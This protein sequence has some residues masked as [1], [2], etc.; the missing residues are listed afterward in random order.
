MRGF[1]L[2]LQSLSKEDPEIIIR[3]TKMKYIAS[4]LL[5]TLFIQASYAQVTTNPLCFDDEEPVTIIYDATQGTTGLVG[6]AKVYMHA[7]VITD[8][9]TGTGWQYVIGNWGTDDGIGEMTK[10]AGEAN[11][12]E[13]TITPR[14]Y[15]NVPAS[16]VIYR[17]GM[18]FRNADGSK[19]GKNDSNGDIFINL[20]TDPVNLQI[21]STNPLLVDNGDM[22]SISA[23]TCSNATFNLYIN[24][25]LETTQSATNQFSYAYQVVQ[26]A[27]DLVE[28]RLTAEVGAD[29]NEKEFSFSVRTA[30]VSAP[31]PAG[32]IDGINYG[33]DPTKVTLSLLAPFK[34][35]VYVVGDFN[36]WS[37]DPA[38]QMKQDGERFW[39]EIT[40][41]ISGQE[42]GYQ[43]LV[44]ETIWIAD[45]YADKILDPDDKWIPDTTYPSLMVY[46]E[47][48][49]HS[50]WYHNRV[51]VIQTNQQAYNWQN[52]SFQKPAK[53][54]LVIYQVLVRDFLG[55]DNMNYQSLIDTLGYFE[56][57]GVNAI[58]LLPIMEFGGN[59]SW[60]Y[61]PT[62]MFA[63][64]KAYGTKNDLKAFID[65]AHGRGM[66]VI[67]DMVM[68][69]ND[70]PSPYAQMYF[71]FNTFKPTLDNPWFNAEP[72]H[73]FNVFFDINHESAYTQTWLDSINNY[74][75]NE[76][77]FDGFRFDLSKGFT[78]TDSNGDVGFWGQKDD[79]RI[80]L[81]KRMA[82]KI[83]ENDPDTYVILEHFA[84][85]SEEII[86]SDYGMLLWGNAAFD[87]YKANMGYAA[88]ESIGWAYYEN[89]GW[90]N[91]NLISY[92]ESHDEE[93]QMFKNL[94]FGNS[95]ASYNIKEL[96]TALERLKLSA[97]F[98]FTIPGPKHFWQFGE[99]GYDVSIDVNGRTGKKP[100]K[101]EYL[102]DP[103]R[104]ALHDTY[105][106][107]IGLRNKYDVFTKGDFT[108]Q[109]SGNFKSIHIANADTS[110]VIIGN[111]DVEFGNINPQFQHTG[112]WYDFFSGAEI[113]IADVNAAINLAPGEYHIYSDKK[114]HTSD[115]VLGL[116]SGKEI[117]RISIYPNPT[118]DI[119]YL[120][121]DQNMGATPWT[122]V[123]MMG[124]VVMQGRTSNNETNALNV[125]LLPTGI[126]T[127][128]YGNL[129]NH[130]SIKFIKE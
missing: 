27:G 78:Q 20:A 37:I 117:S 105:K 21:T 85:N 66:A 56:N 50:N 125:A 71:D 43:Y 124:K 11:K 32:I 54:N 14:T 115:V 103:D 95:T 111:F 104:K 80:A 45:P 119:L 118:K 3:I 13:I 63:V 127:I 1:I 113:Q 123:N 70:I 46:P 26:A 67:L 99:F 44:D 22:V 82:D 64:D 17:L 91:K 52:T 19:E 130:S 24:G 5:S 79:S 23:T 36:N 28:V 10:V 47:G 57:L 30:T 96:K 16:D 114:L 69:Q 75:V 34:T 7:G 81:L 51:A 49:I 90:S 97:T 107:L 9:Q 126:Y 25:V 129:A 121:V 39:L 116:N 58:Q 72:K 93:R 122:I 55:E 15:F 89:R 48:A 6:A 87:F 92:M 77:R 42:Y 106:A 53:E 109:P 73:P 102:D 68:N 112:T 101:W 61:N 88:G 86:L 74:W 108:W 110:V 83:W 120:K 31:R 8:S 35:S 29:M 76:F 84:D 2:L 98:F 65:A 60:G 18:V 4:I 128:M 38:Y 40:G 33:A 59:D 100:T 12:W 94:N 41:L 62:F